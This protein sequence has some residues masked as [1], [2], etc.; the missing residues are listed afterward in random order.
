MQERDLSFQEFLELPIA[1]QHMMQYV[2]LPIYYHLVN[3]GYAARLEDKL[4]GWLFVRG[5]GPLLYVDTLAVH[6]DFRRR[7]LGRVLLTF[8]ETQ[9][10]RLG[11]AW[12][13]LTVTSANTPAVQLYES[14]GFERAHFQIYV[15][16]STPQGEVSSVAR[17]LPG[18]RAWR[19][20]QRLT[21][22]EHEQDG[23][24]PLDVVRQFAHFEGHT[25]IG[26]FWVIRHQSQLV[27]II[28]ERLSEGVHKL[29]VAADSEH[30]GTPLIV[31]AMQSVIANQASAF[32]QVRFTSA[33]HHQAAHAACLDIGFKEQSADRMQMFKALDPRTDDSI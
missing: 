14:L 2:G 11:R 33:A 19:L 15:R 4:A 23:R 8:A 20:S 32:V 13:G 21:R 16:K 26:R 9:A 29:V 25:W 17:R 12:L 22:R 7:G 6:P 24:F 28:R 1:G 27:G 5:R 30:W 3:A 10:R 18:P 31:D